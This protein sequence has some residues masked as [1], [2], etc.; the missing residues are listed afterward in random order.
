MVASETVSDWRIWGF[1]SDKIQNFLGAPPQ[2]PLGGLT[3]PPDPPAVWIRDYG[4]S[5]LRRSLAR[6]A[7]FRAYGA[8]LLASLAFYPSALFFISTIMSV[9]KIFLE[10]VFFFTQ[11]RP[12]ILSDLVYF[13]SPK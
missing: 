4:A 5:R 3:A 1:S 11:N 12:E 2:T 13:F 8:H 6:S 9:Q 10:N 7:R